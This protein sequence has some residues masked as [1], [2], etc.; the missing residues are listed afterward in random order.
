MAAQKQPVYEF[1]DTGS[2]G[3][4]NVPIGG[5]CSVL[6][7]GGLFTL[8][9]KTGFDNNTTVQDA[10]DIVQNR[11]FGHSEVGPE[12][13]QGIQGPAG[14]QGEQGIEGP[15]GL[16]G[17]QGLQGVT[18]PQGATGLNG[19][20]GDTGATGPQGNTGTT[21]PQGLTGPTGPK[22]DQGDIGNTGPI[23][24]TGPSGSGID[25]QGSDTIE[26]IV[27]KA[28]VAGHMWISTNTGLDELGNTV[29]IGDGIVSEGSNWIT[30]GP[31]RGPEGP[32]GP[33]GDD[34]NTGATGSTGDIGPQGIQGDPGPEG[35]QGDQGIQGQTGPQ[36]DVG[37][38]GPQGIQ[39]I[40]GPQG[41]EG[42]QGV[43]GEQG[44][45]GTQGIQ[46]IEG[47]QGADGATGIQ[48]PIGEVA[49]I[50]GSDT[51]ANITALPPTN[52]G[53]TWIAT[54]TDTGAA[55]PGVM[56]DGYT[57]DGTAWKNVGQVRGPQGIQGI[58]GETGEKGT[59]GDTGSQGDQGIQGEQGP[60][61]TKGDQGI[62]GVEGP[63][64]GIGPTGPAVDPVP[65][66][67]TDEGKALIAR[68][69]GN[70][71][72]QATGGAVGGGTDDIFYE[73]SMNVT[74]NYTLSA[75]KNAMSAGPIGIDNGVSVVVPDGANWSVV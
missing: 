12:G 63:E 9:T 49:I 3:I 17:L 75:G 38:T 43:E 71:W 67:P 66:F 33:K 21:G 4:I 40:D 8:T 74:V 73:N 35:P 68:A 72:E 28:N 56:G 64:G 41:A 36:G 51:I 31:I 5:L 60:Q 15:M 47:P 19:Q 62:Q 6:S 55:I 29:G 10:M 45:Q 20:K 2:V 61:G 50:I 46:G 13:P 14:I 32:A 65:D 69:S 11:G 59:T 23:G 48:G 53:H 44:I 27:I 24:A 30:V 39:G 34:G 18:G 16:Q 22:G 57:S 42:P 54:D 58:Q 37:E 70:T 7:T 52:R 25:V 26:N 1:N